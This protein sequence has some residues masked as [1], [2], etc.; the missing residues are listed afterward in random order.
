MQA[1][2]AEL[3]EASGKM[4]KMSQEMSSMQTS[5]SSAR[6]QLKAREN[7]EQQRSEQLQ[8]LQN[9]A[10]AE[11]QEAIDNGSITVEPQAN[12]LLLRVG[13]SVLFRPGQAGIRREGRATLDDITEFLQAH[14]DYKARVEGHTDNIPIGSA[15]SL[16][17]T[18]WEL[19]TARAAAAVRYFESKGIDTRRLSVGG[20]SF[21]QPLDTNE[22]REGR[23]RNR[24]IEIVLVAP[25]TP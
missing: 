1:T 8:T 6:G 18:N 7:A 12:G 5:L 16:W 4:Q 19:S 9:Q 24:R 14:P 11:L 3:S 10:S 17:P 22:T 23:A 25:E 15:K 2:Q 20:Y 21:H 13:G